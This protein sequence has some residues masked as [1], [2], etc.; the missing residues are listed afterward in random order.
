MGV[1]KNKGNTQIIHFNRVFPLFSP[2]ILGVLPV[3]LETPTKPNYD[4]TAGRRFLPTP[5]KNSPHANTATKLLLPVLVEEFRVAPRGRDFSN[6]WGPKQN[7]GHG[8]GW[9]MGTMGNTK[10]SHKSRPENASK[11]RNST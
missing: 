6:T 1:S 2:S 11:K 10:K 7:I 9:M 5:A 8:H 3:F 4:S